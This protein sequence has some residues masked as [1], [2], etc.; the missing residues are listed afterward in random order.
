MDIMLDHTREEMK[1]NEI[2]LIKWL[3]VIGLKLMYIRDLTFL[4]QIYFNNNYRESGSEV[5]HVYCVL[6]YFTVNTYLS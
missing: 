2:L 5:S 4:I 3:H 1:Q 6:G